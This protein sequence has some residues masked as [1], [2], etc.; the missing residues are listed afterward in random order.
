[1]DPEVIV[2]ITKES[3][4]DWLGYV[5]ETNKNKYGFHISNRHNC[6]ESWGVNVEWPLKQD[7]KSCVGA[8]VMS[9]LKWGKDRKVDA[10]GGLYQT[11]STAELQ[12]SLGKVILCCWNEHN[13]YYPHEVRL[14]DNASQDT[15]S[16]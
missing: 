10:A 16:I 8:K 5:I 9:K 6:C 1:M 15:Q 14:S 13:G 12:T 11:T 2:S 7:E 4:T 3:S